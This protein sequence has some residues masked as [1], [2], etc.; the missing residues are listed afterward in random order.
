M[1]NISSTLLKCAE[2]EMK[3]NLIHFYEEELLAPFPAPKVEDLHTGGCSFV[4]SLRTYHGMVMDLL[5]MEHAEGKPSIYHSTV[6]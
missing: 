6:K 3:N 4:C 1:G 2:C 5:I